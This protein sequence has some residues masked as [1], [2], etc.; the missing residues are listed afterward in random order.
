VDAEVGAIVSAD[1]QRALDVEIRLL[2]EAIY[3]RYQH[4]FRH[5]ALAS[6]R[7]R[8]PRA[9]QH[10][11]ADSVS[12]LQ[13]RVLREPAVLRE[14]L[15]FLTVQVTE[16]F[17]DPPFFLAL[18]NE[19]LPRLLTYPTV[20]IWVAGCSTGEEVYALSVLL[21]EEGVLDRAIVYATD[22]SPDALAT[23]EAGIYPLDRIARF[24][25]SYAAAGGRGSLAD[26]YTAAYGAARFDP[27]LRQ[28]V[29]F[30]DH[31]LATDQVFAEVQLVT[32]RNVLIYFDG[33][34][35]NRAIGLFRDALCDRGYL[36]LGLGETL[37][38]SDHA[39]AFEPVN[40]SLRLY[41]KR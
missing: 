8:I 32:C 18:R 23:A 11:G 27:T 9:L 37:R 36:G 21:R 28:G 22:V 41:R 38:F 17:R 14:L 26:H 7:R 1:T 20:R 25:A 5:Y 30:S 16:M 39:D 2:L 3:Q 13:G 19:I 6:L 34:L 33:A 35:Q 29:V 31:S 40:A 15:A 12:A 24:S 4:D 10:F